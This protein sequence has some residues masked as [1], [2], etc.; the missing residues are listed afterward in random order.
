MRFKLLYKYLCSGSHFRLLKSNENYKLLL[1]FGIPNKY[2]RFML[3]LRILCSYF[4]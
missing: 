4:P 2:E 1:V 3:F